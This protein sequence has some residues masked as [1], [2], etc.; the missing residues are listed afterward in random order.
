[1]NKIGEYIKELRAVENFEA[2]LCIN[3]HLPGPRANLELAD[4]AASLATRQ[5]IDHLLA[6]D[7]Q[8]APEH[9]MEV[10]L[11]VCGTIALG[12]ELTRGKKDVIPLLSKFANDPRWRIR[13][14]V[15][16]ALQI[17]GDYNI[18]RMID[19][20]RGMA[21]GTAYEQR[22]AAAAICEPRLLG[23]PEHAKAALEVLDEITQ[24]MLSREDRTSDE[25][26]ALRKG[27]A[28]C[29][30][31][32]VAALPDTGKVRFTAWV[33]TPD[34]DI[35]WVLRENLKK[36]RLKKIDPDWVQKMNTNL[37]QE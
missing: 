16:I 22:A 8:M 34:K 2:Y 5:Q 3:S 9:S 13:E 17:F 30:S 11:A 18:N 24:S 21:K 19:I 31:V 23:K 27:L 28:Y 25:F 6:Y 15:A 7:I 29:W 1:M 35:R 37:K 12:Y 14:S 20:V 33:R 26:K 32:A 10:F 36:N 4:A